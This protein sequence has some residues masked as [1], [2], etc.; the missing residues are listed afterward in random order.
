[1]WLGVQK[2]PMSHAI[3][4]SHRELFLF[5]NSCHLLGK[6]D[7]TLP[8]DRCS[9]LS[10]R[11]AGYRCRRP[12]GTSCRF[13]WRRRCGCSSR[14]IDRT[15]QNR[16]SPFALSSC[17]SNHRRRQKYSQN[18]SWPIAALTLSAILYSNSVPP[19]VLH[20][21]ALDVWVTHETIFA[22]P[23]GYASKIRIRAHV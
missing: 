11:A 6:H 21:A 7:P 10:S 13:R 2:L 15:L 3:C 20:P 23:W 16:S 4:R 14:L 8:C 9:L 17:E 12:L 1:M 19:M 18:S 5:R 22:W